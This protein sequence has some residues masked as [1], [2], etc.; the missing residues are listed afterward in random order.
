MS[1]GVQGWL[2]ALPVSLQVTRS[3]QATVSFLKVPFAECESSGTSGT[4]RSACP[5]PLLKGYQARQHVRV[6]RR[7]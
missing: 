4:G 3:T 2:R 7:L 1:S 6:L 5:N